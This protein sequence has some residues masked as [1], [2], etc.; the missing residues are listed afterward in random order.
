MFL[1]VIRDRRGSLMPQHAQRE[2][3]AILASD[4]VG[5]DRVEE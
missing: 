3:D 2:L 4:D 1:C 5:Y